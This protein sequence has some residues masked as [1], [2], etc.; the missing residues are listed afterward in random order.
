MRCAKCGSDNREGARFCGE[1]AAPLDTRCPKCGAQ[2]RARAKFCDSC[3]APLGEPDGSA[4]GEVAGNRRPQ[5]RAVRE[6]PL[7]DRQ[8]LTG[9]DAGSSASAPD[10]ERKT[11]TALFA[12]IK[13]SMEL[14]EDLDPE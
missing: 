9:V 7:Q 5:P 11:I 10:G 4:G 6:P 14:M 2:N 1:C 12:D 3:S 13:G 8:R